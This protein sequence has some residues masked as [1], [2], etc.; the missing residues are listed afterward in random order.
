MDY[1]QNK[2]NRNDAINH[3]L[4]FALNVNEQLKI[5]NAMS[6]YSCN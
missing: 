2:P 5:E 6:D 3:D 1:Q 4:G